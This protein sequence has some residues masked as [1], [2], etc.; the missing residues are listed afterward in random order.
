MV[1]KGYSTRP[2]LIVMVAN[3][4]PRTT[5]KLFLRI[6]TVVPK[7][8]ES[9]RGIMVITTVMVVVPRPRKTTT[10]LLKAITQRK[11]KR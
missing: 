2:V 6:A 4:C 11:A 10:T 8:I 5:V 3:V 7:A 1:K 9:A